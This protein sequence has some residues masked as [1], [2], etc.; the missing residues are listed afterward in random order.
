MLAVDRGDATSR[1]VLAALHPLQ[2]GD[3]A[4]VQW[5]IVAA[6]APRPP[7]ETQ[8]SSYL[9]VLIRDRQQQK[10]MRW[11]QCD[12]VLAAVCRL[13]VASTSRRQAR[14][15]L[16]RL[17]A[18]LRGQNT[19]GVRLTRRWLLPSLLVAARMVCH[20]IPRLIWPLTLTS[21]EI[22]GLLGLATGHLPIPLWVSHL[23]YHRLRLSLIPE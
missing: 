14:S 3:V 15:T 18:A 13:A 4:R 10:A 19:P 6:R 2:A 8:S 7:G 20:S 11:H 12:P 22:A 1:H 23:P 17:R 9:G 5:L 16:R 21:R